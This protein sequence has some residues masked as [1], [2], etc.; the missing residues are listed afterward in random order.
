MNAPLHGHGVGLRARHYARYLAT[1]P[2]VDFVEAITEN[3]LSPGGRPRAVLEQVRRDLPVALH[4]V[5][6]SIGGSDPLSRSHLD[7]VADLARWVEPA[8]VSDHLCWGTHGGRYAHDLWPL[9]YTEEA[10]AHVVER[11][12]A[13][14]DRLGRHL[15]LE[16]VSSYVA[17]RDSTLSE[18]EFL[19]EV[20]RR[21]DCGILLDVNNVV[22]SARNHGFDPD[23]YVA[24][25]PVDRVWQLYL[26]GHSDHG[27]YLL[28]SHDHPVSDGVWALY[29][30]VVRRFGEVPSLVEWDDHIPELEVLVAERDHATFAESREATFARFIAETPPEFAHL[31]QAPFAPYR[32]VEPTTGQ[33]NVGGTYQHYM[34]SWVDQLWASNGLTVAKPTY[35][36]NPIAQPDL[37]AACF[38]HVGLGAF[39]PDGTLKS[40][41]TLWSSSGQFYATAPAHYYARF[42]HTH[43]LG[44]KAYGFPYDDVGGYS[45]YVSRPNPQYMLIAVGW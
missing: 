19:G 28:D 22:V 26:A 31:A 10:L 17:F 4:G 23:A 39:N 25:L 30:T 6:L 35:F 9:P 2:R 41:S 11:V 24:G 37:S 38:W 36:C 14:Q 5:S 18:W 40:G 8:V 15:L 45:S 20:A 7:A 16:N 1:T 3:Y 12:G 13:V 42:W 21:A 27:T 34:D 44:G 29:R 32:I 33:F 43:A